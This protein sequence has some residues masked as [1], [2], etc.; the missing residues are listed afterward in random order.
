MAT[1]DWEY[2][3][4]HGSDADFRGWGANLSAKLAAVGLVQTADT[5]QINWSTVTRPAVNVYAGYEIWRYPDSSIF[6][7]WDFG[8]GSNASIPLIRVQ[9]GTSSTGS[10]ALDPA[11]DIS[12]ARTIMPPGSLVQNLG[13]NFRSIMSF[14][15]G[16]FGFCGYLG[17]LSNEDDERAFFAVAR[18]TDA[19]AAVT[20]DGAVVY[21]RPSALNGKALN[22]PMRFFHAARA[23]TSDGS[24][25]YVPS[26]LLGSTYFVGLNF[27]YQAF[28]NW[29][30][31]PLVRPTMAICTVCT[32]D[33]LGNPP[34]TPF[35]ATLVGSTERT[36]ISLGHATEGA[37][38]GG[39]AYCLAMLFE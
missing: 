35:K 27:F 5:G 17:T 37:T 28:V 7:K 30:A 8:T 13:E 16:F 25:G 2:P 12:D 15:N 29:A 34:F 20:N 4:A 10:G 6:M 31:Y 19:N 11:D 36:Y 21:W 23:T 39:D 9:V 18:T 33:A 26:T 14:S 1:Q 3:L 38:N 32:N 22:Q 24:Y